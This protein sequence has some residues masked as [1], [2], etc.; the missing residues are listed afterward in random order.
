MGKA[1]DAED[2]RRKRRASRPDQ[3]RGRLDAGA[4]P[5]EVP[6]RAF[7]RMSRGNTLLLTGQD[8]IS[9]WDDDELRRGQRKDKNGRF[10]GRRPKVVPTAVHNELVRR[11]L[12]RANEMLRENLHEAIKVL[13]EI[14]KDKRAEDKDRLRAVDM[15]MNRVM[16]KTP[17]KI[18]ITSEVEPWQEAM[19][20]AVFI[21]PD[22]EEL[23]KIID[24]DSEEVD[25]DEEEDDE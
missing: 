14:A 4:S 15:I 21:V 3:I 20:D 16:G 12:N 25:A 17:E 10:Q 1:K 19:D 2:V 13:V 11:T 22:E 23:L 5:E 24:V 6:Q 8:D 18:N 7:M 9:T